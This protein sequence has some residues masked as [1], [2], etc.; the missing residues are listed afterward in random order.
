MIK[1]FSRHETPT[2]MLQ[3]LKKIRSDYSYAVLASQSIEKFARYFI[4]VSYINC[5]VFGVV[6][7]VF[8][9]GHVKNVIWILFMVTDSILVAYLTVRLVSIN[10][11]ATYGL[12][13]LYNI[14]FSLRTQQLQ[15]ENDTLINRMLWKNVGFTF[16]N[17]F[18]INTNFITSMFTL[19][20]TL[21]ITL[22][23]FLYQ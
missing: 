13:D 18:V 7:A 1:N 3:Q 8:A 10:Q 4:T 23:N 11:I 21:S 14:S 20:L 17:L 9:F 22:A 5:G 6:N 15:Y 19:T 16:G 2:I 12:E